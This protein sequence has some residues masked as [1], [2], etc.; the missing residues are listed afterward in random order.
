MYNNPKGR[1][2]DKDSRPEKEANEGLLEIFERLVFLGIFEKRKRGA[3]PTE[4]RIT[5]LGLAIS[6]EEWAKLYVQS[7]GSDQERYE[8]N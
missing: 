6:T 5:D 3:F 4:Y 1:F 7:L 8:K 2:V